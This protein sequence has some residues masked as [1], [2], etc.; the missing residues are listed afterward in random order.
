MNEEDLDEKNI[1]NIEENDENQNQK[2]NIS[3]MDQIEN[4]NENFPDLEKTLINSMKLEMTRLKENLSQSQ[5]KVNE[6]FQENNKLKLLQLENSKKLSIK[7]D[8]INSNKVEINR[9]QTKNNFLESEND[10]K[11]NLIRI[12]LQNYR[13]NPKN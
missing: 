4:D 6:L 3:Q 5:S 7:E 8:I 9:L 11:K 2:E 10:T 1:N 13:I 12:K